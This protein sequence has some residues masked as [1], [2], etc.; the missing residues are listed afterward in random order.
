MYG[1][2]PAQKA[3]LFLKL[4]PPRPISTGLPAKLNGFG[5]FS[6]QR[7]FSHPFF[8]TYVPIPLLPPFGS[9]LPFILPQVVILT[10]LTPFFPIQKSAQFLGGPTPFSFFWFCSCMPWSC[11]PNLNQLDAL[12]GWGESLTVSMAFVSSRFVP[13]SLLSRVPYK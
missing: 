1:F 9:L 2:P 8:L 11:S 7:F 4:F 13:P 12:P 5:L 3:F 6:A 10:T